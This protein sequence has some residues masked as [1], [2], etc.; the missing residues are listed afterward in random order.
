MLK[1]GPGSHGFVKPQLPG[2]LF[3]LLVYPGCGQSSDTDTDGDGV[4]DECDTC[5][6]YDDHDDADG[7]GIAGGCDICPGFDAAQ[8]CPIPNVSEWGGLTMMLLMLTAGTVVFRRMNH[9]AV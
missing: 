5:P 8:P 2:V 1:T 4:R 3:K 6:G 9:R 7:D